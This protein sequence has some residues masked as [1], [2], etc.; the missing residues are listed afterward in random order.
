[1]IVTLAGRRIDSPVATIE[2][3]PVNNSQAVKSR[4]KDYFREMNVKHL[5]CSGACGADLLAL[6]TAGEM[7]IRRKMILPFERSKFRS[8]SVTDVPGG[9][10]GN[11]FD[12]I[13]DELETTNDIVVMDS[14]EDM[15][16]AFAKAN[17]EILD[18]AKKVLDS[19][20]TMP[21]SHAHPRSIKALLVWD[22]KAKSHEDATHHFSLLARDRGIEVDEIL[23]VY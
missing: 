4:I 18:Q 21:D 7:G 6:Q 13:C 12:S 2:R 8:I 19:Y 1:M 17:D 10:W 5:V 23:T 16:V 14:E 3:F 9:N 11:L 20:A 22:G 15:T